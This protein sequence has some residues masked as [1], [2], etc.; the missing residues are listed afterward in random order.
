MS[1]LGSHFD[2]ILHT[3]FWLAAGLLLFSTVGTCIDVLLRYAFNRPIHWM[4]EITEYIMLYI[5]FLGAALVLKDD[6]H[7]RVDLILTR[8][9]EKNRVWIDILTSFVGG[10][11][12]LIYTCFGAKVTFEAIKR[13]TPALESLRTPMFL[14]WMVI[15]IGS[16]FFAIQFF[17]QMAGYCRKLKG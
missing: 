11:V 12:M 10:W 3:F 16:F 17:R 4:L 6:G 5:P 7:I 13:W 15:P 8:F 2:K 9:N 14:I 1:R